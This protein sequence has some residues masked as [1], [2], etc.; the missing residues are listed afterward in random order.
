ML[1]VIWLGLIAAGVII[2]GAMGRLKDVADGSMKGAETAVT[3]ALG[4]IGVMS[5]WLGIMRLPRAHNLRHGTTCSI[6]YRNIA[7]RVLFAYCSK[8]AISA[9]VLCFILQTL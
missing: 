9:R 3:I 4:L 8:P 6:S 7:R 5:V 1:N 2:G